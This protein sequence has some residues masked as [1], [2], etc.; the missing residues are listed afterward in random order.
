[1]NLSLLIPLVAFVA[2]AVLML[3]VVR[4]RSRSKVNQAFALYLL[5]MTI[6][7]FSSFM[8]HANFGIGSPYAWSVFTT[9]SGIANTVVFFYFTQE[10]LS[11]TRRQGWVYISVGVYLLFVIVT[12]MGYSILEASV[13]D[14]D[15]FITF[16]PGMALGAFN[17]YFFYG[18][19]IFDLFR[20][21]KDA[22][23]ERYRNRI[24]YP[25]IGASIVL[26]GAS[27]NF[28]PLAKFPIDIAAN[29]VNAL[30]ITYAIVRHELLDLSLVVRKGLA[31]T[32]LTAIL[33][34]TYLVPIL[35]FDLLVQGATS[36]ITLPVILFSIL[37]AVVMA[38][39]I[40]PLHA[41]TKNWVDRLFFR[42]QY[43]AYWM[44]Q[45]LGH[46]IA[47]TLDLHE[48]TSIL[49][50][51][52]AETLHVTAVGLLLKERPSNEF[53][54]AATQGFDH[55]MKDLRWRADHPVS[56]WL[57]QEG[58]V[59]TWSQ[60]EMVPQLRA[61]WGQERKELD[62]LAGELLVP[63]RVKNDLVGILV[64]GPRQSQEAYNDVDKRLLATL[65]SQV[66]VAV[67]NA[68]LYDQAQQEII[69]RKRA[70]DRIKASLSEKEILL[71][72]V[73]HRV[74]NNLQ[75]ISSLLDL[76]SDYTKNQK[77]HEILQESQYR[78][79]SM[80]LIHEHLYQSEDLSRVDFAEYVQN[81]VASLIHSYE[82]GAAISRLNINVGDVFLDI[83]VAIPCGLIIN[84]LVSNSLKH[85]FP[86]G[87]PGEICIDVDLDAA[88]QMTLI[89]RDSGVGLP[90]ELDLDKAESLGLEL[91]SMLTEKLKGNIELDRNGGTA[92][93]ITFN[94]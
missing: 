31:Y 51:R 81:L 73:Y 91:V 85:A 55:R 61:L 7:S 3:I 6:W 4:Q 75:V 5:V 37:V 11:L 86:A 77:L 49:L 93:K 44:V 71:K 52:V 1:M 19:A 21:Y 30:L 46:Q 42:E 80:A 40:Q 82:T 47:A 60:L 68:R 92:F 22:K 12:L 18:F 74:K 64:V 17:S 90:K 24:R 58:S 66:A 79:Q 87:R 9:I 14:G 67:E 35:I 45:E 70:E 54:P 2:Y 53:Y 69:E 16:G 88:D 78:I 28:T 72:E 27:T 56:C 33:A 84:E 65:A 43:D 34:F 83:D 36:G 59:L 62:Q 63:L 94:K 48:L 32:A 76:Q 15:V 25:L 39:S 41:A 57:A 10:F 26:L 38:V 29:L 13:L 50:H 8:L 89:V 23:D 20:E